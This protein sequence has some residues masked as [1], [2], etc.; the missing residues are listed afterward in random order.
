MSVYLCCSVSTGS[1]FHVCP[2]EQAI[3]EL[4][5][6]ELHDF[7]LSHT[8]LQRTNHRTKMLVFKQL[9]F[10]CHNRNNTTNI[11]LRAFEFSYRLCEKC[12]IKS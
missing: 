11:S 7:H 8:L 9:G 4:H 1:E 10:K 2:V 6:E 12:V 3:T 5:N